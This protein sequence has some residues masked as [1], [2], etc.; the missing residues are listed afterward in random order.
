[1]AKLLL[2]K[3]MIYALIEAVRL[4]E[5]IKPSQDAK[6]RAFRKYGLLGGKRDPLVTAVFYGIMKHLGILD[7]MIEKVIGVEPL[8]LD[9]WLRA[10]LRAVLEII[11]FRDPSQKTLKLLDK[12]V[13]ELISHKT[14]PYTGMY[15]HR[16]F[17]TKL[18]NYKYEPGSEDEKIEYKYFLPSWYVRKIRELL[19]DE[20]D[21]LIRSLDTPLPIS[22][23]VNTL[24]TSVDAIVKQLKK[25]GKQ[26]EVSKIVPTVIRFKGPYNFEKSP[27]WRKGMIIMQE[28]ASALA[29]LILAPEPG[30]TVVDIAAAPGGKTEHMGELMKNQGT[31][32]AFDI[33]KLRMQRLKQIIRRAGIKIVKTYLRDGR[34]APRILG[35]EI[36]D[37]VLV[38]APCSSDGTLMK[39]PDL[40]WRLRR[41]KVEELSKLQYELLEAG[42]KLLRRGGRLLYCT[43]SLLREEN[44][45]VVARF[46]K[47]HG[48]AGLVELR[49]PYS[50]GFIPGTM[51]AWPHKHRTI[52][53]FYALLEKK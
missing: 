31:I 52:G 28:E 6:R 42:W 1:M 36:A 13:A 45:D 3:E 53:F 11:V 43:C 15:Y 32:Y 8:I 7:R 33:N 18:K 34:E 16:L 23:R 24:K 10:A 19:G 20:T 30:M 21:E 12:P 29:S 5:E 4:A 39:N 2:E 17:E 37:R 50:P 25:E 49:G 47:K 9:P 14:H 27:I 48:N 44:E 26:P 51:R 41:E 35:E 40:R 46:L 38:D 22:I